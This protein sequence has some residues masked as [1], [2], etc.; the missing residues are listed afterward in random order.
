MNVPKIVA[1][2]YEI[3]HGLQRY[4][5]ARNKSEEKSTTRQSSSFTEI[6]PLHVFPHLDLALDLS[7]RYGHGVLVSGYL[8]LTAVS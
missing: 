6:L 7:P 3:Y 8:A 5:Y 1:I 2:T 4:D